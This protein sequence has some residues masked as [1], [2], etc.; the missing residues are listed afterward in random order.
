MKK[1]RI[2]LTVI[3][4]LV[5]F[6]ASPTLALEP[7]LKGEW[8]GG[9]VNQKSG[10]SYEVRFYFLNEEG[11]LRTV[12]DLPGSDAFDLP[13][14]ETILNGKNIE[15]KRKSSNGD[16]ILFKG[17]I[18][19]DTIMGEFYRNAQ[20]EGIFQL[21][22]TNRVVVK[23]SPLPDF[24][25]SLLEGQGNISKADFAGRYYLLDFWATWCPPC[26]EEMPN[27][28][29]VYEKYKDKNFT[30]ISLSLDDNVEIIRK[31][32][33]EKWKM[34]WLNAHLSSG[35]GSQIANNFVVSGVPMAFLVSTDGIIL[36][37]GGDLTGENLEK[38]LAR[39]VDKE[40]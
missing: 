14:Y 10:T 16:E 30:M 7:A 9:L 8:R 32:R 11:R 39:Y 12:F 6:T 15:L 29:K 24:S 33:N 25:V 34:P 18:Q 36:A 37:T 5:S 4:C 23:H 17:R 19:N 38:T 27:L 1:Q 26:I 28:H 35:F 40:Y 20:R 21:V 31:F 22:N 13:F 3:I 2:I